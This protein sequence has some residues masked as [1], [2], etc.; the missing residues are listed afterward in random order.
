MKAPITAKNILLLCIIL[1][2]TSVVFLFFSR[3][4]SMFQNRNEFIQSFYVKEITSVNKLVSLIPIS[5]KNISLIYKENRVKNIM[6]SFDY[7]DIKQDNYVCSLKNKLTEY[8]VEISTK[9]NK[10]ITIIF[11]PVKSAYFLQIDVDIDDKHIII[12]T[13]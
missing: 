7:P 3:E 8:S 4:K 9:K 11:R 12:Q 10:S 5:A 2:I 1:V 13:Y 6:I